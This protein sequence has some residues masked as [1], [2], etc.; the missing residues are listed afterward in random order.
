MNPERF[1]VAA[2]GW[3]RRAG[4]TLIL[5]D[6]NGAWDLPGGRIDGTE[7]GRVA[8]H[9][10]LVRELREEVGLDVNRSMLL[11]VSQWT[12]APRAGENG[13]VRIFVVHFSVVAPE[14]F[15]PVLSSEHIAARWVDD[16][17]TLLPPDLLPEVTQ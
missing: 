17:T 6:Q 5:Q 14:G 1:Y 11:G 16:P 12:R 8:F 13:V 10:V 3:I 9:D 4:Q 15:E 7:F 2:K